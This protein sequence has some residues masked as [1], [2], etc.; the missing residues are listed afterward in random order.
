MA[1]RRDQLRDLLAKSPH[2]TF[3]L[4]AL[5]QEHKKRGEWN[6]ALAA[7]DKVILADPNY[8]YAYF[9]QGQ[10]HEQLGDVAAA[11]RAYE[12]GVAS[13]QRSGDAHALSELS[14]ALDLL[15]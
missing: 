12:A 14:G 15:P 13:A 2:D 1:D 3:L 11:R 7:L 8:C 6:D 5:S 4:Y 10:V 9:Q